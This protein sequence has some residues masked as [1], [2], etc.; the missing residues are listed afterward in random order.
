MALPPCVPGPCAG[1][2]RPFAPEPV[3]SPA[4]A[5]MPAMAAPSITSA[6]PF[7]ASESGCHAREPAPPSLPPRARSSAAH[8]QLLRRASSAP[9]WLLPA[10]P[11]AA[12]VPVRG[13]VPPPC[14]RARAVAAAP[15]PQSPCCT[16]AAPPSSACLTQPC[17]PGHRA[18]LRRGPCHGRVRVPLPCPRTGALA[19]P[20]R[21]STT[22][23]P[24]LGS[25][26]PML[27]SGD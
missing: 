12:L 24:L 23:A 20:P 10:H 9:P 5:R 19:A 27:C 3:L 16:T 17:L 14:P 6:L 15:P 8:R 11:T 13:S 22:A 25:S 18:M 7:R 21:L 2:G 4:L 1:P 26:V